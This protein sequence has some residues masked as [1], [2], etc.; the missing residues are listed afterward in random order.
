MSG[1]VRARLAKNFIT[2]ISI[3]DDLPDSQTG[4]PK[5]LTDGHAWPT[6]ILSYFYEFAGG[7]D[8]CQAR[9]SKPGEELNRCCRR[10]AGERFSAF[11]S[12]FDPSILG[13]AY[14]SRYGSKESQFD[15]CRELRFLIRILDAGRG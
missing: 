8:G 9:N 10:N 12:S 6:L 11:C 2:Q 3:R 5:N 14:G 1:I 4:Q 13:E 15:S 7:R